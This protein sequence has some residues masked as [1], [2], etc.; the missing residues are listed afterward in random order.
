MNLWSLKSYYWVLKC[1]EHEL[2][3]LNRKDMIAFIKQNGE[4]SVLVRGS[5]N[6]AGFD[7]RKSVPTVEE[8]MLFFIKGE[9]YDRLD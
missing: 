9:R 1:K 3:L 5:F 7:D 2:V 4:Y 8:I 6:D